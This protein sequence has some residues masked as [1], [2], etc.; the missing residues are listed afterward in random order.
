M[1]EAISAR[2]AV[3]GSLPLD[4]GG[5]GNGLVEGEIHGVG[6]LPH[7][8]RPRGNACWVEFLMALEACIPW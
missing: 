1:T 8:I 2:I 7:L 6:A 4:S 3:V 5:H